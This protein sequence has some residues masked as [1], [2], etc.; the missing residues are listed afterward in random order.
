[1]REVKLD[2]EVAIGKERT[3]L[4][5]EIGDAQVG[6]SVV[7][8]DDVEIH[9]DADVRDFDLGKDLQGK[10]LVVATVVRDRNKATNHTSVKYVI[11]ADGHPRSFRLDQE[12]DEDGESVFYE[13]TFHLV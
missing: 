9:R 8:L 12:V 3:L 10:L 11:T 5:V 7:E 2:T 1:M 4:S 6:G 13:A